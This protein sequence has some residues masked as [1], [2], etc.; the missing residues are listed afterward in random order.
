MQATFNN[1]FGQVLKPGLT[2]LSRRRLPQIDGQL[3]LPGLS[4]SVEIIR[5]RWG[6]PHIYAKNEPDLFFAQGFVHAQDRLWQMELNR[7]TATGRLSELF[8]PIALDTDRAARTF[9]FH[10]LAQADLTNADEAIQRALSAY[11]RGVN[12]F[13]RHPG[14][15]LPVEFTLIRHRPESWRNEDTM[16]FLR[17]MTW[18]LSHAWYSTIVRAQFIEAV[19]SE[20]AAEWEVHYP[21]QNPVTLPTGIEFHRLAPD[22]SLHV[23]HSPFLERGLGSNAWAIAG[24]KTPTGQPFLCN[25]AHLGLRAPATWYQNHLVSDT[26]NVTGVSLPAAPMV[27]IG[28]NPHIAW[29]ITLAFTDCEDLFIEKFDPNQPERY[30][31][32]EDWR[33]AEV[34]SESIRI[35]DRAEPH[36]EQVVVTH[37]GP[38]ISDITGTPNQRLAL[39]SMA[40][41]P[42][43]AAK[44]W[45][46]LNQAKHWDDFVE[47]MHLIEA[48]QLN[49]AYADT[50]G[51]IGYWLTGKVPV[52]AKGDGSV[53]V[54][55]WN[56]E[57]EWVD[58]VPFAKMPHTLN[59]KKGVVISCN[60]KV[61]GDNYPHFLGNVW[62]NGYRAHR[63]N[64]LFDRQ[65][66][67]T[68]ADFQAMQLDVTC[69]PGQEFVA[70]LAVLP[71]PH[72]DHE[73]QLA[74]EW[75]LSWD[76]Q[77][78]TDSVAG[79]LYE[80][81]RRMLIHNLLK[82]GLG[83]QLTK[84]LL[85]NGFNPVLLASSE[86]YGYDT[87]S[88]LR[89]LG[90]SNS[91]WLNQAGGKTQ[92]LARSLKQ[93]VIWLR[94][95]LGP[96]PNGWQW[97]KIHRVVFNHALG[98]KQPLDRI[99]NRGP[100]PIGGD[101][102]TPCQTATLPGQFY[103]SIAWGPSIRQII[104]MSDLSH[105][106]ISVP[107]GQSGHIASPH[108]DDQ[109]RPWLKGEYIPMLWTRTQIE[110][111]AEGRLHLVSAR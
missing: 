50:Q 32:G 22:G 52:R 23:A 83:P 45:W 95:E 81:T 99:F 64:E 35:K 6:V 1:L 34:I 56:G 29:G 46:V 53:P 86:L 19:G 67:Y 60:H 24:H 2:W 92:V 51:N 8:G 49:V 87:V 94:T 72:P 4:A 85:G 58:E 68:V 11:T 12:A 75:L 102:D 17:L 107:P 36:L 106:L 69:P 57:Y 5:D 80:V 30:Q 74:L 28:H 55:G 96:D 88:M 40:L 16:A 39:N 33:E 101:T 38:I 76:G 59:P 25:D 26:F 37:H 14:C 98:A 7:R 3:I 48:P 47:A 104:D 111:D 77:L 79:C 70:H 91:W 21:E 41:R 66:H 65:T 27:M 84:A 110:Q 90:N 62:M 44:G 54:P 13:L 103:D 105:S 43:P 10:R 18:Q 15:R 100:L 93:A 73:V 63:L 61:V 31:F 89:I 82:P 9:G 97:G 109:F 42:S 108:Y 71:N 78:T 20:R